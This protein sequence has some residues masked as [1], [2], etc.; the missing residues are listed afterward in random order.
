MFIKVFSWRLR[1]KVIL[2]G[3]IIYVVWYILD[4]WVWFG[5]FILRKYSYFILWK[6]FCGIFNSFVV[7]DGYIY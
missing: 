7:E 6:W 2:V 1:W 4:F 3:E 5:K